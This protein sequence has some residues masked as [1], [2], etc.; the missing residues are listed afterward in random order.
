MRTPGPLPFVN[1]IPADSKAPLSA[2]T[3]ELWAAKV[4]GVTSRR[5]IVG[6]DTPEALARSRCSQRN[7][8]R[9]AR[10]SSLVID[11]ESNGLGIYSYT[12]SIDIDTIGIDINSEGS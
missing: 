7:S 11:R 1:S 4:P 8:A 6:S 3:V 10:M 12:F 5:F 2:V 9:A